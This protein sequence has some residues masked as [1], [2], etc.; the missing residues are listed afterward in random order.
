GVR[1]SDVLQPAWTS[2]QTNVLI[3]LVLTIVI[4]GAMEH[5]LRS[6]AAAAQKAKQLDL[7]LEHM[8]QGIM[9]VTRDRRIPIINKRC[10]E[11]LGLPEELIDHPPRFDELT[12][13]RRTDDDHIANPEHE[14]GIVKEWSDASSEFAA[15]EHTR[16]DGAVIEVHSTP[17]PDGGFVQTFTDVT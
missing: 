11:L 15:F 4:L 14:T 13:F 3:G 1:E 7:T 5:I 2:L 12:P 6:E 8:N 9:L 17:L 10:G 16:P